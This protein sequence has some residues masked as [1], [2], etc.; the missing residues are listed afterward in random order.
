MFELPRPRGALCSALLC[1]LSLVCSVQISRFSHRFRTI[2]K[3]LGAINQTSTQAQVRPIARAACQ[4][5]FVKVC[6]GACKEVGAASMDT[7]VLEREG[8]I[9]QA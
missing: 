7:L 4:R 2:L 5:G 9:S 6:L 3:T 1:A 8:G